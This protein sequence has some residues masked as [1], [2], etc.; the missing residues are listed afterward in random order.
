VPHIDEF[1]YTPL[2][3]GEWTQFFFSETGQLPFSRWS[4]TVP[5]E[6][7]ALCQLQVTDSYCAGDRFEVNRVLSADSHLEELLFLTPVVTFDMVTASKIRDGKDA[8]CV[9][10]TTDATTAWAS[11]NWSKAQSHILEE[12]GY[13]IVIRPLLTP[14]GSG[15]AYLRVNCMYSAKH[16][17]QK[18][19]EA[20]RPSIQED[21]PTPSLKAKEKREETKKENIG[22][23]ESSSS[24]LESVAADCSSTSQDLDA[25]SVAGTAIQLVRRPKA[26]FRGQAHMCRLFGFKPLDLTTSNLQPALK[27]LLQCAGSKGRAWINTNQGKTCPNAG[28]LLVATD[29]SVA[30]IIDDSAKEMVLCA[31]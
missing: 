9:P 26:T 20:A 1:V 16:Q 22:Q 11:S 28:S 13:R 8:K 23:I 2:P 6:K 3:L 10:F 17:A 21:T 18:Q 31:E 7:E 14:Y 30:S 19:K 4:F 15:G 12:G 25:C 24:D 29:S 27:V 5:A